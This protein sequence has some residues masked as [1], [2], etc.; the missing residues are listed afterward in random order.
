MYMTSQSIEQLLYYLVGAKPLLTIHL[1]SELLNAIIIS[2][3]GNKCR[4]IFFVSQSGN[5]SCVV[6]IVYVWGILDPQIMRDQ[7]KCGGRL[8]HLLNR[9]QNYLTKC[10]VPHVLKGVRKGADQAY[11]IFSVQQSKILTSLLST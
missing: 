1:F 4:R 6:L 3:I 8:N 2:T 9:F 11:W 7:S 5:R 10:E